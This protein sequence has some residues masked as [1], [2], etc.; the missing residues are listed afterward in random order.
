[1]GDSG[2][3]E[4]GGGEGVPTGDGLPHLGGRTSNPLASG[5]TGG[6]RTRAMTAALG[7]TPENPHGETEESTGSQGGT[8]SARN[9]E[10]PPKDPTIADSAGVNTIPKEESVREFVTHLVQ[11]VK[12]ATLAEPTGSSHGTL[13]VPSLNMP[14]KLDRTGRNLDEYLHALELQ[15][16]V[17]PDPRFVQCLSE[18][19]PRT[20]ANGVMMSLILGS[21]PKSWA[22]KIVELKTARAALEWIKGKYTGEGSGAINAAH[23]TELETE[24]MKEGHTVEDHWLWKETLQRRL[25]A[26]GCFVD[27]RTA[28]E[29]AINTLPAEFAQE[30]ALWSILGIDSWEEIIRRGNEALTRRKLKIDEPFQRKG[31][32]A[33]IP[34]QVGGVPNPANRP[35]A[36][37]RGGEYGFRGGSGGPG[38]RQFRQIPGERGY[39]GCKFCNEKDHLMASCEKMRAAQRMMTDQGQA[40]QRDRGGA[41]Q[42]AGAV[43]QPAGAAGDNLAAL[44]ELGTQWLHD[45][46]SFQYL[47]GDI[48][49]FH[50]LRMFESPKSIQLATDHST[51]DCLGE[52]TVCLINHGT[53]QWLTG[54]QYVPGSANLLS[55]SRAVEDGISFG[56]NS[57]GE[58]EVAYNLQTGF[59]CG[60]EKSNGMYLLNVGTIDFSVGRCGAVPRPPTHSC[61]RTRMLHERLGHPGKSVFREMAVGGIVNGIHPCDAPCAKCSL[62]VCPTC[63]MGKQTRVPFGPANE[64]VLVTGPMDLV[65]MDTVGVITPGSH[66]GGKIIL[67]LV[68]HYSRLMT[69]VELSSK[70]DVGKELK[71]L[72]VGMEMQTGRVT[73]RIRSDNGSEFI[74]RDVSEWLRDRG[75]AHDRSAPGNPQQNGIAERY[76]RLLGEKIRVLLISAGLSSEYWGEVLPT[77]VLLINLTVRKG[78]SQSRYEL[79]MGRKPT[80]RHLRRFGCLAYVKIKKHGKFEPVSVAGMFI[81]YS[82][83]QKAYRVAVGPKCVLISPHVVF[84]ESKNGIEVLQGRDCIPASL[85]PRPLAGFQPVGDVAQVVNV[86]EGEEYHVQWLTPNQMQGNG[87]F[88]DIERRHN[89]SLDSHPLPIPGEAQPREVSSHPLSDLEEEEVDVSDEKYVADRLGNLQA[90]RIGLDLTS[91]VREQDEPGENDAP[92]AGRGRSPKRGSQGSREAA[93]D[94]VGRRN[95]ELAELIRRLG[96][97]RVDDTVLAGR[98]EG[99]TPIERVPEWPAE[100]PADGPPLR[101]VRRKPDRYI[102]GAYACQAKKVVNGI[103]IPRSYREAMASPQAEFWKAACDEE[104]NSHNQHGTYEVVEC[105]VGVTPIPCKWI[106]DVKT[107]ETGAIVRFKA[108][109]VAEGCWQ[110]PGVDYGETFAPVCSQATRRVFF[111]LGAEEDWEIHQVDVKTAFLN[112]NVEE[113][114]FMK[115]P[116]GYHSGGLGTVCRLIRSLYGLKQAPRQWHL[117]LCKVF[118]VMGF[119][120]CHGDPGLFKRDSDGSSPIFVEVYVDDMLIGGKDLSKVEETKNLLKE[121]FNIHDL[122]PVKYFLGLHVERDRAIRTIR[123][124]A[125]LKIQEL[126]VKFGQT[127]AYVAP[128]PMTK[129]FVQSCLPKGSGEKG[130]MGSGTLLSPGHKFPELVGSLQYLA[131]NVRPEISQ[132]VGVLSRYRDKPTTAHWNAGMRVLRYLKG[133]KEGGIQYGGQVHS[134]MG[135]VDSDYAGDLDTRQSTTGFVFLLN[136]GPISWVSRKQGSVASSTVEAEYLAFHA[137]SKEGRWLATLLGDFGRPTNQLPL[138]GDNTG[139]LANLKNVILSKYVKHIGVAYHSAREWVARGLISPSYVHTSE[140]MADLFTKPL[141]GPVF[142]QHRDAMG[143]LT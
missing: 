14:I 57:Q 130:D 90:L 120:P 133:T 96:R 101:R 58:P 116:P 71:R 123:I 27:N 32:G 88:I 7:S 19:M 93:P 4:H 125:P 62:R 109:L 28:I 72:L 23:R 12:S 138:R 16:L 103:S 119:T 112:G 100:A 140:N 40:A 20:Q 11:A 65:H 121:R 49:A 98:A 64:D 81:G 1:M 95:E 143:L 5:R 113:M 60:I 107:D 110:I 44:P 75:T 43:M 6:P 22:A 73:R 94:R 48:A 70:A 42:R 97:G 25:N 39:T 37:G 131:S 127:E 92:S 33:A 47:C 126:L 18:D 31:M 52:G 67:T 61:E 139:C 46:G 99:Q 91:E 128:T 59:R 34:P 38:G 56:H 2:E 132:A 89:K 83:G 117:E 124:T 69:A 134:V 102:P 66:E 24:P 30:K 13:R 142:R 80:S 108:R 21:T 141:V 26:N 111:A 41:A 77:A 51:A 104:M 84:D 8:D 85:Q 114:V 118:E 78:M 115:Q 129:D 135:Y 122:G 45:S 86:G 105:P 29:F 53:P 68:D 36:G 55:V 82:L 17:V 74:N 15:G 63:V 79:F 76:N 137:A 136:G 106:F 3:E 9:T 87:E 54:V 35:A 50:T 10:E